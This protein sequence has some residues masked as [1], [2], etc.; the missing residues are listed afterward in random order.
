MVRLFLCFQCFDLFSVKSPKLRPP[1]YDPTI[2]DSYRHVTPFL[3]SPSALTHF[4]C[5]K[6]LSVD[7]VTC[8]VDMLDTANMEGY[9]P[10]R[11]HYYRRAEGFIIVYAIDNRPSFEEI[12]T[13][14]QTASEARESDVFPTVLCGNKCDLANMRA[15]SFDDGQN[16]AHHWNAVFLETS[17]KDRTNIDETL[18]AIIREI[19]LANGIRPVHHPPPRRKSNLCA[20]M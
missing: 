1:E 4:S 20:V 18:F 15:V 7:G 8:L 2:E 11:E 9:N 3:L 17:A 12:H 5:R 16:V 19:R 10:M 6:Q 13:F 14:R